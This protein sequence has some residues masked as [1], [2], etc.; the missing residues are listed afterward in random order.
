MNLR[1]ERPSEVLRIRELECSA[2]GREVEARIVDL[3]RQRGDITWSIVAELDGEIAGHVMVSPMRLEPDVGLRCI[4][5]GPI[6]VE[7]HLQLR[8]IGSK[9][10][11]EVIDR[12]R[13][14]AYD[15][16][17]LLGNPRYY[18]RFGFE[19]APLRNEYDASEEFMA[20]QLTPGCLDGLDRPCLARYIPA[21]A[22][23]ESR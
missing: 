20:F 21:F 5:I 18:H 15:V 22:D 2:F 16:I 4:A 17:L 10:M 7:P 23:A 3:A 19:T 12:A 11:N 8:G 9:L 14:D 1:D 13:E 6:G